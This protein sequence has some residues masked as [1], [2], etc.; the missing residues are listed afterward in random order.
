MKSLNIVF[1]SV[2][3]F[4]RISSLLILPGLLST[5]TSDS[6]GTFFYDGLTNEW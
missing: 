2:C 1:E 3:L 6:Q 4:Q 5:Q